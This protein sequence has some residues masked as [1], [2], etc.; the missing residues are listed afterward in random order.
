MSKDSPR[1]PRSG[2]ANPSIQTN[3]VHHIRFQIVSKNEICFSKCLFFMMLR[4]FC[5]VVGNS[6]DLRMR[7]GKCTITILPVEMKAHHN[8]D[9]S[10]IQM[11]HRYAAHARNPFSTLRALS[12]T[13]INPISA[14]RFFPT[15][16]AS[17]P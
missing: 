7:T 16:F 11:R 12:R 15:T 14:P 17:E 10:D 13:A 4:L 8:V 1:A 9:W 2:A 5:D 6:N 3:I